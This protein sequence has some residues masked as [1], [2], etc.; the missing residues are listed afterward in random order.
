MNASNGGAGV[1]SK[2]WLLAAL[3]VALIVIAAAI[4]FT[5]R[6]GDSDEQHEPEPTVPATVPGGSNDGFGVPVTDVYGRRVDVPAAEAGQPLPQTGSPVTES[7]PSW[8]TASPAGTT[9]RGG[10]Q[11]VFGVSV[12]FSTSDGPARISDGMAAG[13]AH[14]PRGAALAGVY[15]THQLAARPADPAVVARVNYSRQDMDTYRSKVAAGTLPT[16]QPEEV[17]RWVIAPDAYQVVSWSPDLCVLKIA[18]RAK[19]GTPQQA[20]TWTAVPVSVVW[21]GGDWNLLPSSEVNGG[22]QISSILGW[23]PW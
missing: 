9:G 22:Q 15:I 17:T 16:H 8:L 3:F 2:S 21:T 5:I 10:W 7:D 20:P 11:R 1:R 12:P 19:P 18:V 13:Y 6:G 14:S 4:V 23:T